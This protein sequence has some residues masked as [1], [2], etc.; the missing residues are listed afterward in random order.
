MQTKTSEAINAEKIR[1]RGGKK[2][3]NDKHE[4]GCKSLESWNN[5]QSSWEK[6]IQQ[7]KSNGKS[8]ISYSWLPNSSV[9]WSW[10]TDL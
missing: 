7:W 10:V 8:H 9:K 4:C 5:H 3:G 1:T 2:L 6:T